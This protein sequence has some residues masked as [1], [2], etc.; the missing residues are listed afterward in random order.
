MMSF[1]LCI[2]ACVCWTRV[3]QWVSVAGCG[4]ELW[5]SACFCVC[6]D[7]AEGSA[8]QPH[9]GADAQDK[10]G[11]SLCAHAENTDQVTV[12][13][14]YRTAAELRKLFLERTMSDHINPGFKFDCREYRLQM[15]RQWSISW[16]L[17]VCLTFLA[18]FLNDLKLLIF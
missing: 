10:Q 7:E 4:S 16:H 12:S 11:G 6:P 13:R 3:G 15:D 2:C 1:P 5:A 9:E 18:I 8:M 14:K 17:P